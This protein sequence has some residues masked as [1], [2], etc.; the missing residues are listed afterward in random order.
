MPAMNFGPL[1]SSFFLASI[2]GAIITIF[3]WHKGSLA[4]SWGTSF[5]LLFIIMFIASFVSMSR[6]DV[7]ALLELDQHNKAKKQ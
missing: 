5:L 4:D 6:A 7:D 3:Y 1:P 2:L